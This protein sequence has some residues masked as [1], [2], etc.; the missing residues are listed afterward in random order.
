[1]LIQRTN[2]A[3]SIAAVAFAAALI[4]FAVAAPTQLTAQQPYKVIDQGGSA[5]MVFGITSRSTPPRIGSTSPAVRRCW[6]STPPRA[7]RLAP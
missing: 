1:M 5:A 7:N 3:L 4:S 6:R 2:R